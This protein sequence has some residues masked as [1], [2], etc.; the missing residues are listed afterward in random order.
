MSIKFIS[1]KKSV[2]SATFEFLAVK[3]HLMSF[4]IEKLEQT[5]AKYIVNGEEIEA[6][7]KIGNKWFETQDQI[8]YY[9][10]FAKP[11]IVYPNMT[12]VFPFTYD[13]TGSFG[14]DK[15]FIITE[16]TTVIASEAKQSK[17]KSPPSK[18]NSTSSSINSTASPMPKK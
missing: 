3:N 13:E 11:K 17:S 14:N 8:G 4:G 12:S 15:S 6:R 7:K 10:E 5:G 1:P 2:N 16:K 18:P 9:K